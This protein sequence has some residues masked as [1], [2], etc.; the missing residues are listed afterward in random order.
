MPRVA[1]ATYREAPELAEDDRL[2][3]EELRRRGVDVEPAVWDLPGVDWAR[4]DLV[5]IRSTWD[6]HLR[7]A[8]YEAWVL[9]F[10]PPPGR[11]WNPASVV[12]ATF[13]KRY[14]IDLAGRGV[15][16]VPTAYVPAGDGPALRA[17]VE[18]QG[19]DEVVIKPAVSAS[20]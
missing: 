12:L 2:A 8:R 19:W 20:A 7:P 9:G 13:D 15:D 14:L 18:G 5:V 1:F 10:L 6:Y 17:I 3:A 11:L 16:V 4:F